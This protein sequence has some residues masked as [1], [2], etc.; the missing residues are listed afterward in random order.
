M[1]RRIVPAASTAKVRPRTALAMMRK[2]RR[3][4]WRKVDWTISRPLKETPRPINP[5]RTTEKV[6]IP[7]PPIWKRNRVTI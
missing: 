3:G 2:S 1:N 6:M 7:S 4:V 5:N